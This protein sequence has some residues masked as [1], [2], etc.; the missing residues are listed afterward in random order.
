MNSVKPARLTWID[1]ARGITIILV[2]YRHAFEGLKESGLPVNNYMY[3]EYIN[4]LFFSFRMPLFFIVSGIFVAGSLRKRGVKKF[5][6]TKLRSILYPYFLWAGIQLG[7]QMIF[8]EYTNGKPTVQTFLYLF[9]LPREIAHFWYLYALFNVSVLFVLVK[10]TLRLNAI[11]QLGVGIGLYYI[12]VVTYQQHFSIGFLADICHYYLFFALGNAVNN[13]VQNTN[14][15]K[16]FESWK[17]SLFLLLP[18]IGVQV[19]FLLANLDHAGNKYMFVEYFQPVNFVI[20]ALVG[21]IF[22]INLCFLLQKI[23]ILKWLPRLGSHSLY[24]YVAHV[25]VFAGVRIFLRKVFGINDVI[26]LLLA[27]IV[28]GLIVPVMLYKLAVALNM[29]WLFTLEKV[30]DTKPASLKF[31]N[32]LPTNTIHKV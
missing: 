10:T 12:S 18:F 21:C 8:S 13:L 14:N 7:L 28:A 24:I 27:G 16:Y 20:I 22:V 32:P 15:F 4:I 5:I 29:R 2:V 1:Y 17:L 30:N 25:I 9:Y 6:E 11:Q 19:Y 31:T 3:L 23:N 26:I